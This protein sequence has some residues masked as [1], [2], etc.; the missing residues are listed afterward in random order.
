MDRA[1]RELMGDA[2]A[3]G[4][5]VRITFYECLKSSHTKERQGT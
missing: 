3:N 4:G 5:L 2:S 1:A